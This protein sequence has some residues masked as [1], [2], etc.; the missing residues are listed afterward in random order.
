MTE[1][2][3]LLA[4]FAGGLLVGL[5]SFAVL[6]WSL[7]RLVDGTTSW[8]WFPLGSLLRT[9]LVVGTLWLLAAGSLPRLACGLAG[10]ALARQITVH[11]TGR[12]PSG[13]EGPPCT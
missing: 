3:K 5:A 13:K 1:I 11:C 2:L 4:A 7:R 8:W 6:W 10:W 9:V 12:D